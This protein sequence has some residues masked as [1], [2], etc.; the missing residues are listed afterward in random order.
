MAKLAQMFHFLDRE[1]CRNFG[2]L[3]AQRLVYFLT[4]KTIIAFFLMACTFMLTF[5][6][7]GYYK[8]TVADPQ[9]KFSYSRFQLEASQK[10]TYIK[11]P[12]DLDFAGE[13]VPWHIQQ[14]REKYASETMEDAYWMIPGILLEPHRNQ[15]YYQTRQILRQEGVPTDFV[16]LFMAES[17]LRNRVSPKGAAGVCQL[18]PESARMLGLE[19]NGE[20]DERYHYTK[21]LHAACEY[22]KKAHGFFGSW[23][24]AAAAYNYGL[25]GML[26]KRNA[27]PDR[28]Y[29]E[30]PLNP[31][32]GR[33]LYRILCIKEAMRNPEKFGYSLKRLQ[34]EE[35]YTVTV[36]TAIQNLSDFAQANGVDLVDLKRL[37]PWLVWDRLTNP[38]HKS[39]QIVLPARIENPLEV[40]VPSA[41]P[42]SQTIG[43]I[44]QKLFKMR[45]RNG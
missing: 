9:E 35:T 15:L 25:N 43:N 32:T 31:E 33:Y 2:K 10:F 45:K 19:V 38:E 44:Q 14:V 37:N 17:T 18:M 8:S 6:I 5:V 16:Y 13:K 27:H 39:Y 3:T 23:T 42:D 4:L 24:M 28:S 29:Y 36:D 22:L 26:R 21:S 34:P 20:V 41:A 11:V 40:V 12:E 30:I 1:K 7:R